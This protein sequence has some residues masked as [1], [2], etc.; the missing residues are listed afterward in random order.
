MD[1]SFKIK[2]APITDPNISKLEKEKTSRKLTLSSPRRWIGLAFAFIF[3]LFGVRSFF[4]GKYE[5]TENAGVDTQMDTVS[6]RIMGYVKRVIVSEGEHVNE[7]DTLAALDPTDFALEE[8]IKRAKLLK[9]TH[10]LARAR[11]LVRVSGISKADLEGAEINFAANE[12]DLEVTQMKLR[13]SNILAPISGRIAKRSIQPGQFIQPGQTLFVIVPDNRMW[14][15]GLF[16]ESQIVRIHPGM[17]ARVTVDALSGKEF[18]GKVRV[19]MPASTS[20]LSLIPTENSTGSYSRVVQR[21]SV[22][23]DLENLSPELR[24]GMSASIEIKIK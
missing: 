6:G 14:V 15:S 17:K 11:E 22:I 16:K 10:D 13:Y 21:F 1:Q 7:G 23:I 24:H 2:I 18:Y 8:K 9:A 4:S 19:V 20:K 5:S 3:L 12:A